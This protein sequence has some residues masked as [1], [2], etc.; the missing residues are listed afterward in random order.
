MSA[1]LLAA[2]LLAARRSHAQAPTYCFDLHAEK[3]DV[4]AGTWQGTR[5]LDLRA[6]RNRLGT[7]HRGFNNEVV[8]ANF[9]Q[10][11]ALEL[12]QFLRAQLPAGLGGRPV[13][14]VTKQLAS[15]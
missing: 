3:L 5:V 1:M 13:I 11:F 4:P 6:D 15:R 7:V 8:S 12:H 2:L 9:F 10:P 14:L